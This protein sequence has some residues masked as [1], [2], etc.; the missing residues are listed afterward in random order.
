VDRI[1]A[2]GQQKPVTLYEV[3]TVDPMTLPSE[4]LPAW[5]A[6][7]SAWT[8]GDF[9]RALDHFTTARRAHIDD[10]AAGLMVERCKQLIA[11]P[12]KNWDGVWTRNG[13]R[14]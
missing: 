8:D 1:T 12:P 7:R 6:G 2:R 10:K 5:Q 14:Q 13:T 11:E 3:L 9:A 4:W